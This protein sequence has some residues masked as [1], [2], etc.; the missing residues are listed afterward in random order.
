MTRHGRR[1]SILVLML[2]VLLALAGCGRDAGLKRLQSG[3][4]TD[5]SPWA[6]VFLPE[7]RGALARFETAPLYVTEAEYDPV[8]H[9]YRGW[10][11]IR[12]TNTTGRMLHQVILRSLVRPWGPGS[13]DDNLRIEQFLVNG[14][15]AS[16]TVGA[17]LL[18]VDLPQPLAAG[19]A[20]ELAI[21]GQVRLPVIKQDLNDM[22][23]TL[24]P[25]A[26]PGLIGASESLTA[27]GGFP[28]VVPGLDT[29]QWDTLEEGRDGLFTDEPVPALCLT[30][31]TLPD[32]WTVFG[33]GVTVSEKAARK[34]MKRVEVA[35]AGNSC[36][37]FAGRRMQQGSV[38]AGAVTVNSYFPLD[39]QADGLKVMDEVAALVRAGSEVLGA[40]AAAEIDLVRLPMRL[41]AHYLGSGTV[42]LAPILYRDT[43]HG[44]PMWVWPDLD[45]AL[46]PLFQTDY[47]NLRHAQ[48]AQVAAEIWW[49]EQVRLNRPSDSVR[50]AVLGLQSATA[51]DLIRRAYGPAEWERHVSRQKLNYMVLRA[52]GLPDEPLGLPVSR[53]ADLSHLSTLESVKG[54]LFFDQLRQTAGDEAFYGPLRAALAA[55]RFEAVAPESLLDALLELEGA[56]ALHARWVQERNGDA[57][58]GLLRPSDGLTRFLNSLTPGR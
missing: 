51:L 53:Y 24:D 34:N 5:G 30:R 28:L 9:Y 19:E 26:N 39:E 21:W 35:A 31:L 37:L 27:L 47:A 22:I 12:L 8:G 11:Y 56:P 7:H 1:V 15:P 57:D 32:K 52:Q 48:L 50:W 44:S 41:S 58:I 45:P 55:N 38:A 14:K 43:A 46:A 10:H 18:T 25:L 36:Q 20:A 40:P 4:S 33:A 17:T 42:V 54:S 29:A 13:P 16:Y 3:L 6:R 2:C 49:T 23:T